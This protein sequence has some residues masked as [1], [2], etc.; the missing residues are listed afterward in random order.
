MLSTRVGLTTDPATREGVLT[1]RATLGTSFT[2]MPREVQ[3]RE[4]E[5]ALTLALEDAHLLVDRQGDDA[6][7][8]A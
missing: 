6:S 3:R 4:I 1:V 7:A 2:A 8:A 5:V